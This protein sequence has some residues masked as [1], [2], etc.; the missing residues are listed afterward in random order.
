MFKTISFLI[1]IIISMS[2]SAAKKPENCGEHLPWNK[3][4]QPHIEKFKGE[5]GARVVAAMAAQ[6]LVSP[7]VDK[8]K[9]ARE[10]MIS[11]DAY[12]VCVVRSF[13]KKPQSIQVNA[14]L[15][16]AVPADFSKSEKLEIYAIDYGFRE[17]VRQQTYNPMHKID[18]INI[19]TAYLQSLSSPQLATLQ[20]LK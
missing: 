6:K 10:W 9:A 20:K 7:S 3:S 5:A 17:D 1:L 13:R 8:S 15:I 18:A 2:A 4:W 12:Q 19:T 14:K 16:L 11:G